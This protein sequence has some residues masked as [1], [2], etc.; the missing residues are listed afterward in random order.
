MIQL[1]QSLALV[2]IVLLVSERQSV[3]ECGITMPSYDYS[4][5]CWQTISAF[6]VVDLLWVGLY[7]FE[8]ENM[9]AMVML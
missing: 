5:L 4:N 1:R 8:L 9:V 7:M 2:D 3:Q 6:V